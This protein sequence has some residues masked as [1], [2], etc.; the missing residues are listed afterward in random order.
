MTGG[1]FCKVITGY[2]S[3][4]SPG[5]GPWV[6]DVPI[7]CARAA[8]MYRQCGRGCKHV[9]AYCANHGGDDRAMAE[10]AAHH[11]AAHPSED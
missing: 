6:T 1:E 4:S 3:K 9:I 2:A 8:P 7:Y 10:M 5:G 11:L